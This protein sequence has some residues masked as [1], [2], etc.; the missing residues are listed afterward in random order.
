MNCP[1]LDS[2]VQQ[3]QEEHITL[4]SYAAVHPIARDDRLPGGGRFAQAATGSL[5]DC[6]QAHNRH[7]ERLVQQAYQQ[8]TGGGD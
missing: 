2:S 1:E 5:D 3:L 7:E 8:D 6:L 4:R